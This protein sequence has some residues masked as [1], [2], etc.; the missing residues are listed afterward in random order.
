MITLF[1]E[2][3]SIL[4]PSFLL[5]CIGLAWFRYGPEY[6]VPF[7]TTLVL[8]VAGPAL[9]FYTIAT[10]TVALSSLGWMA[11]ATLVVHI[12]FVFVAVVLLKATDKDWRL[13]IAHVVGNTGNLGLPVCYFAFGDEGLAYAM[14]FFSVQS[15]LL[16]GLGDAILAGSAS[17]MRALKSPILHSIWIGAVVRYYEI[18]VPEFILDSTQLLGEI[19]IPIMLVTLGVSLAGMSA[20]HLPSL[21]RWSA[22]RT[23]A[24]V[25]IGFFVATLFGFE[26][27]AKSVL[28][29]QTAVPVAVFN[30][31]MA[32]RH[33]R[34]STEISGLI[35]VTHLAA[36]VYLPVLLGVLLRT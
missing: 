36:I 29:I 34:D 9:Y 16:F 15:I 31:L 4:A 27:V 22:I 11:V 30:Y 2:I 14:A 5:A 25:A 33:G 6:P 10:G 21:L 26:G 18:P 8:N 19:V 12:I 7:V 24:A 20:K 13:C 23:G 17:P 32:I 35:L 3:L 1:F 28:V